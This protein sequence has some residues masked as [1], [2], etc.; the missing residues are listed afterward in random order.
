LEKVWKAGMG[1][2]GLGGNEPSIKHESFTSHN[3][4]EVYK[5]IYPAKI[6]INLELLVTSLKIL[7][8]MYYEAKYTPTLALFSKR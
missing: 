1:L 8:H 2:T 6:G 5:K 4:L 7:R 3:L